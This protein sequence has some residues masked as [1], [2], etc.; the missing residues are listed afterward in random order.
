M[1]MAKKRKKE[2][3]SKRGVK[4]ERKERMKGKRKG[5]IVL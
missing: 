5:R 4:T 2:L 3:L 1:N